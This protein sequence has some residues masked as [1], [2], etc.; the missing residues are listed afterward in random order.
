MSESW[1]PFEAALAAPFAAVQ[2]RRVVGVVG[3]TVPREMIEAYG[4]VPI[5]LSGR[6][7]DWNCESESMEIQ[8][9]PAIQSLFRQAVNGAFNACDLIAIA[10]T[11]DGNRYFYQ[12]LKEM[13]RQG[14]LV[15]FPLLVMV[16]LLLSRST[17]VRRY[18]EVKF[19]EFESRMRSLTEHEIADEDLALAIASANRTKCL[20][21]RV[22]ER[23]R[24]GGV[25]GGQAFMALRA[26]GS[27]ASGTYQHALQSLLSS[28]QAAP[29]D[30]SKPRLLLV[31][32]VDLYHSRLHDLIE[33][34]GA[35]VVLEDDDASVRS[36][37]HDI[38]TLE[39]PRSA[40]LNW[41]Y[42]HSASARMPTTSREAWLAQVLDA[43]W[44][45]GVVFY[46]PPS[47]QYRGWRYPA[48]RRLATDRLLPT[49]LLS[50]DVLNPS[51][52]PSLESA[53]KAFVRQL[54]SG[55]STALGLG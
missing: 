10:G 42:D 43:E 23:R 28:L 15:D 45:D 40:L 41:Y 19:L 11:S 49:L 25:S 51:A 12:Y 17:A 37:A 8:H 9:E 31:S 27:L 16:D 46:F 48:L 7:E 6:A 47:D 26:G 22:A 39:D 13:T 54:G 5:M 35:S 50:D 2:G 4:A 29:C 36:A 44:I 32:A 53:I 55:G 20:Q 3:T 21:R 33:A 30:S 52:R 34:Q 24:Q 1:S 14:L 18:N 38:N